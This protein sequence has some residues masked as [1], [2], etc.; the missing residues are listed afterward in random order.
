MKD[1]YRIK[2]FQRRNKK[3]AFAGFADAAELSKRLVEVV[4]SVSEWKEG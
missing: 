2:D 1:N 3:G 4:Q